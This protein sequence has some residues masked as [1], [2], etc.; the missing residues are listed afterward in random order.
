[1]PIII[2]VVSKEFTK[3]IVIAIVACVAEEIIKEIN[4]K[5]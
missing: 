3:A 4:R 1:M 2:A 5:E